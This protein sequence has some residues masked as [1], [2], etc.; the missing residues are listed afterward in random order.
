MLC[1]KKP[2]LVRAVG[3]ITTTVFL[4]AI[5]AYFS[6]RE[7]I[8]LY[9]LIAILCT[10]FL[11]WIQT[12]YWRIIGVFLCGFGLTG[13]HVTHRLSEQL[14]PALNGHDVNLIGC[15]V[16]LPQ[17]DSRRTR[18]L[19]RVNDDATQA[20]TVR[21]RLLQLSWYVS[22]EKN[23][24]TIKQNDKRHK[25]TAGSCWQFTVR[26]RAIHGVRNP[27]GL[28]REK[29]ALI[30]NISATG[31]VRDPDNAKQLT[32]GHGLNFWREQ[33]SAQISHALQG[34]KESARFIQALAVGDTRF[35]DAAD[36]ELLRASGLSHLIAI[37]GFHVGIVAS[38]FAMLAA[39]IW[40]LFP[41]AGCYVPRP[42]AAAIAAL[43][44]AVIYAAV[45]GFSLP[46]VRTVLMIAIVVLARCLRR[47]QRSTETLALAMMMILI[48]EPLSVLTA[49]FW[50][51]F[52]GVAWIIWC[53][54]DQGKNSW[55]NRAYSLLSAQAVITIGLLP[56]T[57]GLFGQTSLVGPLINLIMIPWWS[58]IVIPLSLLG[59]VL[60]ALHNTWG[61]ILWQLAALAFNPSWSLVQFLAENDIALWWLPQPPWFAV[62]LAIFSGIWILLPRG[63]PGKPIALLLWL[64]LLYPQLNLPEKSAA[65]L[66]V[67]DSGQ[68][69]S[70]LVRTANHTLLYDMGAAQSDGFDTGE[71]I[72]LPGLRALGV[73]HLDMLLVS[74]GDNDH[75]GG[76]PAIFRHY[77]AKDILTSYQ[78]LGSMHTRSCVAGQ[79]WIWDQVHFRILHPPRYFPYLGNDSSCVLQ[80]TTMH[81]TALLTGDISAV[82][83]R[84]I[85][86]RWKNELQTDVIVVSHHGSKNASDQ[87]FVSTINAR[88][89][90]ISAGYGNRFHHPSIETINRWQDAGAQVVVTFNTGAQYVSLGSDGVSVHS[91]R[92]I[93]ERLWD[94]V[95]RKSFFPDD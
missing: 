67:F 69:L 3:V 42:Q 45:A 5:C 46:T 7:L 36:W 40:Y 62:P 1:I 21:D 34:K 16:Q 27:G 32:I 35:I 94:S 51:S 83:E 88:W 71:H 70:V 17:H 68:G 19:F 63:V 43:V 15:V 20:S 92:T 89:A 53:L 22:E 75:R 61:T 23:P 4:I 54:P 48:I 25:I 59:V 84:D 14:P 37:S 72:I 93:R 2:I 95:K 77:P 50:L 49:G 74:H 81:G 80:I 9:L 24:S 28:D 33:I 87:T 78:N 18:W 56:F 91:E 26:L 65:Q 41:I 6:I 58:L 66:I 13:L 55:K 73:N 31:Y 38:F 8:P 10:G 76:F 60:E 39:L 85:V 82:V 79:Q 52:A 12:G 57:V 30:S 90:L 29:Y 47:T 11:L 64:P 44:G 86:R